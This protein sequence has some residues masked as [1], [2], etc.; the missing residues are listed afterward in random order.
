MKY[1][2]IIGSHRSNSQ[3]TKVGQFI[4]RQLSDANVYTLDLSGNPIPYMMKSLTQL[5]VHLIDFG[6]LFL[7]NLPLQ[8]HL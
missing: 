2:L 8:T 6:N 5:V 4:S 3:S 1:S 7:K